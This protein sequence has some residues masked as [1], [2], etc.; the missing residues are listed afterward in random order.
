MSAARLTLDCIIFGLQARGGISNFWAKLVDYAVQ[1]PSLSCGLIMPR[2]ITFAD[3]DKR[4][5]AGRAHVESVHA[6]ITRYLPAAT[7]GR[8]VIFHTSYYRI[9]R[10]RVRKYVVS[11]YD[12]TYERY[13]KGLARTVH[14]L[15]KQASIRQA[16]SVV[17]I[18]DST[19][20]D[21]LEF[22]PDMD[23]GK[24]KVVHLGVDSDMFYREELNPPASRNMVLFVGQR[25]GYKRFD[26]AIAA[27]EQR[28][29]LSLGIVG[30]RLAP[31]ERAALQSRLGSRWTEL[32]S[33]DNAALRR[34]YSSAYAFVFPSDYEG[35]GLP[36][37]EA[38][39]CGCPVVAAARSSLP[40][41]GG[42]A[43]L[44]AERQEGEAYAAQLGLL[45]STAARATVIAAGLSRAGEFSWHRTLSGMSAAYID[46]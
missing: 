20:R 1:E 32:G 14:S 8:D 7:G 13:R 17:C 5:S 3:F 24:L 38:M 18:S 42:G 19:R 2:R 4:M 29:H 35:F 15:Q 34:L 9:P 16:D 33:V 12:F 36:V 6:G 43:A 23:A 37:L 30:P 31:D 22:Y 41:V 45:E 10:N 26:I 40:E 27:L 39:A 46:A 28:P 44:Y 11:V 21:I 25:A